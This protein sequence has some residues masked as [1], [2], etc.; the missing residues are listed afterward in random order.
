MTPRPA[1]RLVPPSLHRLRRAAAALA[2]AAALAALAL[3]SGASLATAAP[4][5]LDLAFDGDGK[6]LG[7][8]VG[9]VSGFKLLEQPDGKIVVIGTSGFGGRVGGIAR[10][11]PDGTPDTGFGS[12]GHTLVDTGTGDTALV[13]GARQPDGK[14]VAVGKAFKANDGSWDWIVARVD[15]DGNL[16]P[17]FGSGGIVRQVMSPCCAEGLDIEVDADGKILVTGTDSGRFTL[18]RYNAN[19]TLDTTFGDDPSHNVNATDGM[20]TTAIG[21]AATAYA[22]A[23]QSDGRI[24]VV[25]DMRSNA[26]APVDSVVA[27]YDADGAL[28][29]AFG[30][31]G[32]T[33]FALTGDDGAREVAIQDDDA[34]VVVGSSLLSSSPPEHRVAYVARLQADGGLDATFSGTPAY[35]ETGTGDGLWVYDREGDGAGR[36]LFERVDIQDDGQIVVLGNIAECGTC[37]VVARL[38]VDGASDGHLDTSFVDD[39]ADDTPGFTWPAGMVGSRHVPYFFTNGHDVLV[40]STAKILVLGAAGGGPY[41]ATSGYSL[42]RLNA[43]GGVD[44]GFDIPDDF[45]DPALGRVN[46]RYDSTSDARALLV[47]A[48]G[49]VYLAGSGSM[50]GVTRMLLQKF[51]CD[52]SVPGHLFSDQVNSSF[53]IPGGVEEISATAFQPDGRIVM[54]GFHHPDGS[55]VQVMLLARFDPGHFPRTLD[56]SFGTGGWVTTDVLG[57]NDVAR[58]VAAQPDGKLVVVGGTGGGSAARVVVAR[59]LA[60]G[61]LDDSFAAGGADGDGIATFDLAGEG[62]VGTDVALLPGGKILVAGHG[63]VGGDFDLGVLRLNADGTL[64]ATFDGDGI[65]HHDLGGPDE[66]VAAMAVGADGSIALAGDIGPDATAGGGGQVVRDMLIVRLAAD[67]SLDEGFDD[68]GWLRQEVLGEDYGTDVAVM[69]DGRIVATARTF[70]TAANGGTAAQDFLVY[71]YLADGAPDTAFGADGLA[72]ADFLGGGDAAWAMALQSDGKVL[73]GG[74]AF[75]MGS[76][77]NQFAVAR[78]QGDAAPPQKAVDGQLYGLYGF[79]HVPA[80]RTGL[81]AL[82]AID[83]VTGAITAT[84]PTCLRGLSALAV[85]PDGTIFA[86]Q[87]GPPVTAS[88]RLYTLDAASGTPTLVGT[89]GLNYLT[90][91]AFDPG[92]ALHAVVQRIGGFT[93]RAIYAIDTA[94]GSPTLVANLSENVG[95]L[96]FAADGTAY[97][98]FDPALGGLDRLGTVDLGTGTVTDIGSTGI[99]NIASLSFGADGTLHAGVGNPPFNHLTL[100]PETGAHTVVSPIALGTP[101]VGA[102]EVANLDRDSDGVRDAFDNCLLTPNAD[103]LDTDGDGQGD[104]CDADDDN[105]G[106]PDGDDNCP[107]VANADQADLDL[108]GQGDACDTDDDNDG[109]DDDVDN[110]PLEYNPLQTDTDSDGIGNA[111]DPDDDDDGIPDDDDNCSLIANADQLDTDGDGQGDACDTDDDNDTV[112]DVDDNCPVVDNTGQSNVDGDLEGDACDDD[113]DNDGVLDADDNCPLVFNPDQFDVDGDGIGDVCDADNDQDGVPDAVDKC[114]TVFNPDQADLDVDGIGDVCDPDIDGDDIVNESDNCPAAFNPGQADADVDGAGDA[115]DP[116]VDGDG[117]ANEVDNCPAVANAGQADYDGDLQGD[118]CDLD[119]DG[120]GVA[121]PDD[122]CPLHHNPGQEDNDTDGQ[123]DVCDTD[124]DNDGIPDPADNCPFVFNPDQADL[125][126]DGAGDLCDADDDNDGVLDAADNCPTATNATQADYDGDGIGD[127]CDPVNDLD[128]DGDGIDDSVDNCP[129]TPNADQA[130]ED[131]DLQ[132]DACDPDDDNDGVFDALDNCP[133]EANPL[134]TDSDGDGVGD[135]CETDDDGDGVPD[136]SDNCP[137]V[138]NAAQA[139]Y[140]GDGYGDACDLDDDD[141]GVADGDDAYP[142][143]SLADTVVIGTCD[144]GVPNHVFANGSTFNDLIAQCTLDNP[145]D[146]GRFVSC[147][148]HLTNAWKRAGLINGAQKG[149]IMDCTDG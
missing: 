2:T 88:S 136:A 92:G 117:V 94:T 96:A 132:G 137:T 146:H 46:V 65:V 8:M 143:G 145:G 140:D 25:G 142:H 79:L 6:R 61:D 68:D 37:H 105:D 123:G 45:A 128:A 31:G 43:D 56:A 109:V 134:Q 1:F 106:V 144:S 112:A 104:A 84:G 98:A 138:A 103:Q 23:L 119:D 130:N 11:H 20:V 110:C 4:G 58:A 131:V 97:V 147:V 129:A 67:G 139:D 66:Q 44:T 10:L 115:C 22:L 90:S 82:V 141:D 35:D 74:Q 126:G 3:I 135:A 12:G 120:D 70:A 36:Q 26:S 54:A 108:D 102:L 39:Y 47:D 60:D 76:A 118:A 113:D 53:D 72:T 51:S 133:L 95:A 42:A 78:F 124:D 55:P 121:D 49:E 19:G 52:G 41:P 77:Q 17:T 24:V 28:D 15:A 29:T 9:G 86:I 14:I 50:N 59:Y 89:I 91:L 85:G 63:R 107:L 34:I 83:Q 33:V 100:D 7:A 64:D 18:A 149:A 87:V 122:N 40:L 80:G 125:D 62:A 114:P 93:E 148:S 38:K 16:D 48:V 127:A 13:N 30:D 71:R 32:H 73:A 99:G 57:A 5:D 81:S 101:P 116:D 21:V 75:A 69:P 27:R 111:C